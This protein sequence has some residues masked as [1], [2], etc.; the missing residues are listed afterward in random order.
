VR[1]KI[2]EH[3]VLIQLIDKKGLDPKNFSFSK[4]RGVLHITHPAK[5]VAFTF[6]R[7]KQT[8]LNTDKQW[9][10][11]E[12]YYFNLPHR[13]AKEISWDEVCKA[14]VDWLP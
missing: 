6:Y 12:S 11:L 3:K 9:E 1:L 5:E 13:G 4:K 7:K 8:R 10:D 2:G 14:F